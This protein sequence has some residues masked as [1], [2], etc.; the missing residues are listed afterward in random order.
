MIAIKKTPA[1]NALWSFKDL[2]E[3]F[4]VKDRRKYVYGL[5]LGKIEPPTIDE[6]MS[7]TYIYSRW[8]LA[9]DGVSKNDKAFFGYIIAQGYSTAPMLSG[10]NNSE[11]LELMEDIDGNCI[12]GVL[13]AENIDSVTKDT[14]GV[15]WCGTE[16]LEDLY[17]T[18]FKSSK[19]TVGTEFNVLPLYRLKPKNWTSLESIAYE[20]S[21]ISWQELADLAGG[22]GTATWDDISNVIQTWGDAMF[23]GDGWES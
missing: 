11:Y 21:T 16:K 7:N 2:C 6:S 20:V 15:L 3:Y 14:D 18:F 8:G 10:P 12:G 9:S 17:G 4:D 13:F 22:Y 1:N 19:F 23:L 5:I